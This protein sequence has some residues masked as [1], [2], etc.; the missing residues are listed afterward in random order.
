MVFSVTTKINDLP[1]MGGSIATMGVDMLFVTFMPCVG[2]SV[3]TVPMLSL[4]HI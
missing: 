3:V 1:T 4:I 2:S